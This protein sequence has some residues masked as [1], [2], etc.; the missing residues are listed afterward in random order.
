MRIPHLIIPVLA[1]LSAWLQ[2]GTASAAPPTGYELYSW[3]DAEGVWSFCVLYNTSSEKTVDEVFSEKTRLRGLE[4]LKR[5][6][7]GLPE[8]ASVFWVDRLPSG[9]GPK[10]KG[11]EGLQYPPSDILE[12]VKQY[13]SEHRVDLK[14]LGP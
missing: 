8:G 7:A 14:V 13:A 10:A 9:F 12:Q 1:V 2:A 5:K 4:A 6:I 11:S 3:K